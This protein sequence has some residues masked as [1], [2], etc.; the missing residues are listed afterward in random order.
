[1]S[2]ETEANNLGDSPDWAVQIV[3]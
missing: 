3:F 1:M 2:P